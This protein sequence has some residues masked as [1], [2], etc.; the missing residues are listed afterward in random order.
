MWKRLYAC[1]HAVTQLGSSLH[2]AYLYR[3]SRVEHMSRLARRVQKSPITLG[4]WLAQNALAGI[5]Y[6][7]ERASQDVD[8]TS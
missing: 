8:R 7:A 6:D 5:L 2:H 4:P 3:P 1:P